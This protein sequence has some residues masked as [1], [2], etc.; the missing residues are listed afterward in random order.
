MMNGVR[1]GV[2]AA[3][4]CAFV[5]VMGAACTPSPSHDAARKASQGVDD[6]GMKPYVFALLQTGD[7]TAR[8]D[9]VLSG[10]FAGHMANIEGLAEEG[11][12]VVA[13]PF[14]DVPRAPGSWRGVFVLNTADT[15]VARAW[16]NQD[17]AVQA[18]VFK[19]VL[20]PW[21]SSGALQAVQG[22][23]QDLQVSE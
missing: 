6:M 9:S 5:L 18:G 10:L 19:V 11:K 16:V 3:W 4:G 17:P 12:L 2:F 22:L 7:T 21:Y 23:H 1:L 15:A 8:P 20:A 13:G 14:Y